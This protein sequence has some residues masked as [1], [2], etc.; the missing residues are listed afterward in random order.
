VKYLLNNRNELQMIV[1]GETDKPTIVNITQHTYFNLTGNVKRDV[2]DHEMQMNASRFVAVNDELIPLG[3]LQDVEDSPFDFRKPVKI[4]LRI[5][6]D[7]IQI[8]NG[9]GYDH[10][11]V[12]DGGE[13]DNLISAVH[14]MDPESGRTLEVS[15][16]E[17]G[18]QFYTGNFLDGTIT[19][20]YGAVYGKR[21]GF[22]IEQGHFPDSP[23][24]P[25]FPSV[26]LNPGEKYYSETVWRFGVEK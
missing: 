6:A 4:G 8:A 9:N 11:F 5:D 14:V 2:L 3:N 18:F 22:C 1:E 13:N 21:F 17:P 20:K 23:N 10:T 19:G 7:D 12:I 15:T 25:Q 24:Q 16:T 26:V